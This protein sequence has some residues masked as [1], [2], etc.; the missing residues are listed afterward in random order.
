MAHDPNRRTLHRWP[1]RRGNGDAAVGVG[2]GDGEDGEAV[3]TPRRARRR[4][5]D[6][7]RLEEF[8]FV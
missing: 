6:F 2:G 3:R 5:E 1:R 4:D 8:T 7:E